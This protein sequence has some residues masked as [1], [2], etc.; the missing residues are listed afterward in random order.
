[1]FAL[2]ANTC[3]SMTS[4][5]V[6]IIYEHNKSISAYEILYWKS[7][8]MMLFNYL[9]IHSFGK[10]C[11]DIPNE[12]RK[13]IVFRAF[14]GFIGIQGMWASVKYMPVSTSSSIVF[15]FPIWTAVF[16]YFILGEKL[17]KYDIISIITAFLG[18][19]VIN[20]PFAPLDHS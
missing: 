19:I 7:L 9:F 12:Y 14:V 6:K 2:A 3:Y 16:A 11:L 5:I 1:M 10:F 13:I 4:P 20:N 8:S 17:T 15:S 18:V